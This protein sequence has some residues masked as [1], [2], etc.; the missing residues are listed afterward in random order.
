[1]T[2]KLF[3]GLLGLVLLATT[4]VVALPGILGGGSSHGIANYEVTVTNL[5]SGQI[6]SP[7]V[8]ATH[9]SGLT[10]LYM[11]GSPASSELAS[12]AEDAVNDPLVALL[13][14]DS[15]V[16]DVQTIFGSGGPIMPGETASVT[17]VASTPPFPFPWISSGGEFRYVTAA[18]MLVTTNDA[19]FALN[20]VR[21]PGDYFFPVPGTYD[22]AA[23][24]AGSEAN[25]EECASIPGPPCGNPGIRVTEGAEGYVHVHDGVHGIGDLAPENYNWHNPVATV[26]IRR[27]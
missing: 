8:V 7:V 14:G 12:I 11:F 21:L 17:I 25:D 2:R 20:G 24:D 3:L 19:F 9:R 1:M 10:P 4:L 23:Y 16:M 26:T 13:S 5:T 27:M 18:A 22:S 6:I 15:D